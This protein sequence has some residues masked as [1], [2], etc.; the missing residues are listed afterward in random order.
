MTEQLYIDNKPVDIPSAGLGITL[1]YA[2]NILNTFASQYGNYTNTVKLPITDRNTNVF[3]SRNE[4]TV[5]NGFPYETHS[6]RYV[7]DGIEVI[8]DGVC[9][10]L[11][12]STSYEVTLIWH[13]DNLSGLLEGT[14]TLNELK[15]ATE[16]WP[17]IKHP[18]PSNPS[19]ITAQGATLN[20]WYD[21]MQENGGVTQPPLGG[22]IMP[23]LPSVTVP[24]IL[25]AIESKY[26][27]TFQ[28]DDDLTRLAVPV[29]TM[30][31]RA[32]DITG[33]V[34]A[35]VS[36]NEPIGKKIDFQS[37][38]NTF[39][40]E[41]VR[42]NA[43]DDGTDNGVRLT[44][45]LRLRVQGTIHF[46]VI[47]PDGYADTLP[48]TFGLWAVNADRERKAL[49][50]DTWTVNNRK[51]TMTFDTSFDAD[52]GDVVC[53]A[54]AG[55]GSGWASV[56]TSGT[57][58]ITISAPYAPV[59]VPLGDSVSDGRVIPVWPNL[60]NIKVVDF[61]RTLNALTGT[62]TKINGTTLSFVRYD[63]LGQA[64]DDWSRYYTS[65]KT[66]ISF[67]PSGWSR[68]N[69]FKWDNGGTDGVIEID[70]VQLDEERTMFDSVFS[71]TNN[72]VIPAFKSE[73]DD[74][75]VSYIFEKIQPY[76]VSIEDY[77][78]NYLK[79]S[80]T[81]LDWQSIIN[82]RYQSYASW[83]AQAVIVKA[84]FSLSAVEL[85]QILPKRAIYIAQLGC[86]FIPIKVTCNSNGTTT[87]ELLKI[88]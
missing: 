18:T 77:G 74:N 25:S 63:Y 54:F 52:R 45:P 57:S 53:F 88:S 86:I 2:S 36:F 79:V 9:Y 38:A 33:S 14:D 71:I 13:D 28:V 49:I 46:L 48:S 66:T 56:S 11:S 17:V 41:V 43:D 15:D 67:K 80:S 19:A 78:N 27:V 55:V 65:G 73:Q 16:L 8:K 68:R 84:T 21:S 4:V 20:V 51:F 69:L 81:G 10:L 32:G 1:N 62:Y 35:T 39:R 24:A 42:A 5:V 61:I 75:G 72:T 87:A 30:H 44:T 47:S 64:P 12:V 3:Q 83:F 37:F 31:G 7:K 22:S 26:G 6:V 40:G 50:C 59:E 29:V 58:S 60:P 82:A 85:L 70:N 34:T 23:F 76:I